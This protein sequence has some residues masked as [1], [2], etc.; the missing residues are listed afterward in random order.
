MVIDCHGHVVAPQKIW[1]YRALLLANRGADGRGKLRISDDEICEALHAPDWGT[2]GLIELLD[3]HG[4]DMQL[5]S[6]RPTHLMHSEKPEKI[7]HWFL[8]EVHNII[9]RQCQMYPSRFRGVAAL[10]QSAGQPIEQ[11]LPELR[12]CV[13]ELGFVGCLL[14]PDP[15]ENSGSGEAPPLGDRYWYPLYEL[16]CNLDI[17]AHIHSSTSRSCRCG[18]SEHMINEET[19]AVLGLL[20]SDVFENFPQLKIV[21]SHG[22][23]AIPYQ[24]GRFEAASQRKHGQSFRERL[25]LLHFDTVLYT[26]D[27]LEL[28][29][30]TVGVERCL[31]A[32]ECPGVGGVIDPIT[33]RQMDDLKPQFEAMSWLSDIDR[34]LIFEGNARRLFKL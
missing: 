30:K 26:S 8:E 6:P 2:K 11:S 13:E 1:A 22:G 4:T 25:R 31:F 23:G 34:N 3:N 28:L 14:N 24:L 20:D 12:R 32:A 33:N 17:P 21:L 10:P 15:Y 27:A 5:I 16:L 29:V 18:Y 9:Y 19:I 7:I